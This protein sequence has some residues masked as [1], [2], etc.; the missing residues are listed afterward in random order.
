ME[1]K[2]IAVNRT[3][4][5]KRTGDGS[6]SP[7]ARRERSIGTVMATGWDRRFRLR[8][9]DSDWVV[10]PDGHRFRHP[11]V[12][13]SGGALIL[14]RVDRHVSKHAKQGSAF[15]PLDQ[16]SYQ[17]VPA[18][19][20]L[21][22]SEAAE[23]AFLARRDADLAAS[24]AARLA[25]E[26]RDAAKQ[27]ERASALAALATEFGLQG[28]DLPLGTD[29]VVLAALV[30]RAVAHDRVQRAEQGRDHG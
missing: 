17:I 20:L 8:G 3:V 28:R 23:A 4:F 10:L 14:V 30:R 18:R 13:R 2:D 19:A 5:V 24:D 9:D 7:R 21:P 12:S 16:P 29:P 25:R 1:A 15:D 27:R 11:R 22:W 26:E 6:R